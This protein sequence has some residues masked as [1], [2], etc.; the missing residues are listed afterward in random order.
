MAHDTTSS[1]LGCVFLPL[2]ALWLASL[3]VA[4]LSPL[5]V[6]ADQEKAAVMAGLGEG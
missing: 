3:P 4:T 5:V 2:W 1:F 6:K